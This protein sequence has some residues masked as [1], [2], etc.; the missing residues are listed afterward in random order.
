MGRGLTPSWPQAKTELAK[1]AEERAQLESTIRL[2]RQECETLKRMGPLPVEQPQEEDQ[3]S[4]QMEPEES[5]EPVRR[6]SLASASP[7]CAKQ[8]TAT[9]THTHTTHTH[10]HKP[11]HT[12]SHMAGSL[13]SVT[14]VVR[15]SSQHQSALPMTC[16]THRYARNPSAYRQPSATVGNRRLTPGP[17]PVANAEHPQRRWRQHGWRL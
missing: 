1:A 2:L 3:A 13:G 16:K 10:T 8:P 11:S 12:P 4:I 9:H 6:R 14:R 15:C 5:L 17:T 7:F